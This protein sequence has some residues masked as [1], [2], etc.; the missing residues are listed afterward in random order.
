MVEED[1][2]VAEEVAQY[3]LGGNCDG[4][5]TNTKACKGCGDIEAD[6]AEKN[7]KANNPD[8]QLYKGEQGLE[9]LLMFLVYILFFEVVGKA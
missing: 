1:D 6:I 7:E 2:K 3:S 9:I 5:T 4:N 8:Q